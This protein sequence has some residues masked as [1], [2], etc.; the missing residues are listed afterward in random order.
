M[1]AKGCGGEPW[2][3]LATD[4]SDPPK[5]IQGC[6]SRFLNI[7]VGEHETLATACEVLSDMGHTGKTQP[8]R[9]LYCCDSQLC[10]VDNLLKEG[11]DRMSYAI[12]REEIHIDQKQQM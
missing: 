9:D 7:L 10:G 2:G 3:L 1:E 6:R 12:A 5:C 8:F 4:V 11:K